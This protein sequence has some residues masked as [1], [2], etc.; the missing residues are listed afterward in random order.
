MFFEIDGLAVL[1][2]APAACD[3]APAATLASCA[4]D[5]LAALLL[6]PPIFSFEVATVA[7]IALKF[8]RLSAFDDST[9]VLALLVAVEDEDEDREEVIGNNSATPAPP[10]GE[11]V[12]L[13]LCCFAFDSFDSFSFNSF[14]FSFNSFSGLCSFDA[15]AEEA[16]SC[17]TLLEL[18]AEVEE[19]EPELVAAVAETLVR[20]EIVPERGRRDNDEVLELALELLVLA[21]VMVVV[22]DEEDDDAD[23][24]ED[25]DDDAPTLEAIGV[26]VLAEC[27]TPVFTT[28]IQPTM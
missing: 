27:L 23:G 11:T 25:D 16:F 7:A 17:L 10:R 26:V 15:D 6:P 20:A 3:T 22:D 19:P 13:L 9:L 5:V 8:A 18:V 28:P 1:L 24:L 21:V 4:L 14:S 12:A 2:P